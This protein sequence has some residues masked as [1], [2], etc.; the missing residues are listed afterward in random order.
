M[1][2]CWSSVS[3]AASRHGY[4]ILTRIRSEEGTRRSRSPHCYMSANQWARRPPSASHSMY[5][6]CSTSH[7]ECTRRCAW[8][9][10]TR[11]VSFTIRRIWA[12]E[13]TTF[14]CSALLA[15]T[16][17]PAW[18]HPSAWVSA[19]FMTLSL[20][21]RTGDSRVIRM[22]IFG[23]VST[24]PPRLIVS[25]NDRP[26]A[27]PDGASFSRPESSRYRHIEHCYPLLFPGRAL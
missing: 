13:D 15:H 8:S 21:W 16:R 20:V 7:A 11:L 4:S 14:A 19:V 25:L 12:P 23:W 22:P 17:E 6:L 1:L 24:T 10:S 9:S 26:Q 18:S 3:T 2:P 27:V 5:Q